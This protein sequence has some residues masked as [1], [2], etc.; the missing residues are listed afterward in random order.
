M[1]Q[2][3]YSYFGDRTNLHQVATAAQMMMARE[4]TVSAEKGNYSQDKFQK[5]DFVGRYEGDYTHVFVRPMW[6]HRRLVVV[7]AFISEVVVD[8]LD[9]LD[10]FLPSTKHAFRHLRR[11]QHSW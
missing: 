4:M 7:H 2:C 6:E 5:R 1:T 9:E 11:K 10:K 8:H 3:S